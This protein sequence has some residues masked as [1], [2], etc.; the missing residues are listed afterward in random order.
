M[1]ACVIREVSPGDFQYV[2]VSEVPTVENGEVV[3]I[4]NFISRQENLGPYG[5]HRRTIC[6]PVGALQEFRM[7][8]GSCEGCA[9]SQ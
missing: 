6:L 1:K 9:C 3:Y 7:C 5:S 8:A 4:G 2:P